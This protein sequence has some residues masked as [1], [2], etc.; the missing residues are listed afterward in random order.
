MTT[1]SNLYFVVPDGLRDPRKPSGGNVFDIELARQLPDVGWDVRMLPAAGT[2]PRPDEADQRALARML[3]DL[4]DQSV[5]LLDG[6]VACNLPDVLEAERNRLRIVVLVHMPLADEGG[7]PADVAAALD[8][9]E[10]RV[11]HC[12][13]AVI[14]TSA[15]T[16]RRVAS[17]HALPPEAVFV[18]LPGVHPFPKAHGTDGVS[19]LLCVASLTETKDHLL[20]VDALA[21]VA[22]MPWKCRF[23]GGVAQDPGHVVRIRNRIARYGLDGRITIDGPLVGDA[24]NTAYAEADLKVLASPSESYCIAVSE[25]LARGLP[26]VAS[27]VGGVPEALGQAPNGDLPGLL[28]PPGDSPALARTLRAWL[29]D[30]GL[31]DALRDA[32]S[33]RRPS[34]L[35]WRH[36]AE[37]VAGVL[38]GTPPAAA[39][40]WRKS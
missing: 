30:S 23:V 26:V 9:S 28:I 5:V 7:L 40:N 22:D 39:T 12:A 37:V 34:L 8:A 3:A 13:S 29:S 31:R 1:S 6:L 20:L 11:L 27:L 36:P 38:R 21:A 10:R 24:L 2:W 15:H 4:P 19:Q 18:A 14:T 25:A 32:A 33:R 17:Q 35:S 16:A